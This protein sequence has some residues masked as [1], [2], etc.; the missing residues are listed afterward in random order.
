[1]ASDALRGSRDTLRQPFSSTESLTSALSIVLS[2]LDLHPTS[3]PPTS[4][5][6]ETLRAIQRYLPSIQISLLT[7][8]LPTFLHALNE[9]EIELVDRFFCPPKFASL[10]A[11]RLGREIAGISYSS[12]PTLLSTK[13]VG[14]EIG[15]QGIPIPSRDYLLRILGGLVG[16]YGINDLYWSVWGSGNE[17]ESSKDGGLRVLR[18]EESVKALTSLPAK[19]ANAIGRWKG[20]GW[21]GDCPPNLIPK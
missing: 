8:T 4:V 6:T 18:W 11:L 14:G 20:E 13:Q 10:G 3:I 2:S 15:S 12:L 5:P 1:M 16:G 19:V 7:S 17:A 21:K 9:R